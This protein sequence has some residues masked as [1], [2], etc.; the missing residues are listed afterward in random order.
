MIWIKRLNAYGV[1]NWLMLF[2]FVLSLFSMVAQMVGLGIFLPIFEFIFQ[3]GISQTVDNQNLLLHYVNL[4]ITSMNMNVTLESL[5]ITA[6]IFYL[7]SQIALFIIA[8]ANAYFLGRMTKDIRDK[9]FKY[10]LGA[11]S[12][13]YDQVKIGD[14]INI[15]TTELGTAVVGVIAPIK[16]MVSLVS[17]IGSIAILM[18]LSYELTF[19]I[20]LIIML[21]LPYPMFLISQTTK[22]GRKNT[23]FNSSLVSF[24][25][26]RL[27]SPRLVRL[28]G[29]RNSEIREYSKITE[30][31]RGLTLKIH[32]LKEKIGLTFEPAIILSSLVI[33]YVAI[34]YLGISSSS[35]LL[36]MVITVRLVPIIR[37]VLVQKQ[38]I[39][40]TKG[41]I[42]SIDSLLLEMKAKEKQDNS[43]DESAEIIKAVKSIQLKNVS[44]RYLDT[45][46]EAL[47]NVS[48][49]FKKGTLNAIIGPSGSGKSTLI[50]IIS[51][52]RNPSQGRVYF[53]GLESSGSQINNL[54]SYVPQQPQIFDGQIIEHISY[55]MSSKSL[56]DVIDATIL[57][58][59]HDFIMEFDDQ[60]QAV[61]NNNGDNLSG[62]QRYKIDMAR[63]LLSDAP[64]LILDEPTSALD[65]KSK[66][67]I[68]A[69]FK[70]IKKET[71]KI[72]IVITHDFSIMPVFDS[73]V[74]L[75]DGKITAQSAPTK[76]KSTSSWYANGVKHETKE[77]SK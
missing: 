9:F 13:Y 1:S 42:E 3:G 38:S 34:T 22:V 47:S 67:S 32:V 74:L 68:V 72:I 23:K 49:I 20:V 10:Y 56:S 28:S 19:Y 6:F 21:M 17:A 11:D 36:F 69:T 76:L 59:A 65:Y 50:D 46:S 54:V 5:L 60:Y 29:T 62:G 41:S 73:I 16:L 7:I 35:V 25:L 71:S 45:D 39:N 4:L 30:K 14:F 8:Y 48:L 37:T 61:L 24:L 63:A 18:M 77:A 26:D 27:R 53:D 64:I 15:S 2:L 12:K 40:R 44:Y 55:G 43:V 75:E 31:Q 33:L 57:S 70:K 52:Y 58:G 66:D 51:G